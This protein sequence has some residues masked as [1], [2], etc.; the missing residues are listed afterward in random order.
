MEQSAEVKVPSMTFVEKPLRDQIAANA[1]KVCKFIPRSEKA[2]SA[3]LFCFCPLLE[4]SALCCAF[5]SKYAK[6]WPSL[7]WINT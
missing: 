2:V 5:V 1:Q 3:A 6:C 4:S 7:L